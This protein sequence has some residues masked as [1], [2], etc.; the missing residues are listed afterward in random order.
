M[1]CQGCPQSLPQIQMSDTESHWHAYS[2]VLFSLLT[3]LHT[4]LQ[5]L[6]VIRLRRELFTPDKGTCYLSNLSPHP[7]VRPAMKAAKSNALYMFG[8][9]GVI[10]KKVSGKRLATESSN[11]QAKSSKNGI[12]NCSLLLRSDGEV[13]PS[14][15]AERNTCW[16]L[17]LQG[18]RLEIWIS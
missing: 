1:Q 8:N 14:Q 16:R 17:F 6:Q 2:F 7:S 11:F 4:K 15:A 12:F 18:S 3:H 5:L 13:S 10:C 9:G